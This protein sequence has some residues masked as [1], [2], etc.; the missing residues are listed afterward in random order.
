MGTDSV[1]RSV[2]LSRIQVH[3]IPFTL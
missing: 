2:N 3:P 1:D